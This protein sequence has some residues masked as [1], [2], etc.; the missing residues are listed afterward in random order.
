MESTKSPFFRPE[1]GDIDLTMSLR[2]VHC[3]PSHRNPLS[4][5]SPP[6]TH[7]EHT[8]AGEDAVQSDDKCSSSQRLTLMSSRVQHMPTVCLFLLTLLSYAFGTLLAVPPGDKCECTSTGIDKGMPTFTEVTRGTRL[9][10]AL[11]LSSKRE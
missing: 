5:S 8:N 1:D 4:H 3:G 9:D 7:E 6:A 2:H 10:E 11:P